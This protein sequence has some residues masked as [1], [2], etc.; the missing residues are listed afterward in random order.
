VALVGAGP[1]VEPMQ[2]V[3]FQLPGISGLSLIGEG[4]FSFVYRGYQDHLGRAVAV[5]VLKVT[6]R[7]KSAAEQFRVEAQALGRLDGFDN[8]LR[9]HGAEILPDGHPY[10]ITELCDG[11]LSQLIGKFGPLDVEHATTIGYQ[12]TRGLLAAHHRGILHGDVTPKNVLLRPSGVPV[13]ADFGMAVLRDYGITAATGRTVAHAAPEILQD[14]AVLTPAS[15]VYGLGST[16]YTSLTGQPPFPWRAGENTQLRVLRVWNEPAPELPPTVPAS[17]QKLVSAMLAKDP[18]DRPSLT[19][20]ADQLAN[21]P[22]LPSTMTM[23]TWSPGRGTSGT[24]TDSHPFDDHTRLREPV[25][26]SSGD[27]TRRRRRLLVV[28]A[29]TGMALLLGAVGVVLLTD[30]APDARPGP[31]TTAP[32]P[33]SS[34]PVSASIELALPKDLGDAVELS[35]TGPPNV[36]YSVTIA[37]RDQQQPKTELANRATTRRV[38]VDPGAQYCFRIE[39]TDGRQTYVSNVQGIRGAI[40]KFG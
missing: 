7:D 22:K 15:D 21:R 6:M 19:D 24:A 10:L 27:K 9:V 3:P 33:P 25:P 16:I 23:T 36:S 5:K 20:V 32:A 38:Q 35:W 28:G 34:A 39:G 18:G 12:V 30:D 29:A 37:A 4:G 8:V 2:V 1:I 26:D 11:S 13:L 31:V 17:L 40:C 14:D